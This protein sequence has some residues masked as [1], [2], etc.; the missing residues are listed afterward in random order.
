M[1]DECV[2]GINEPHGCVGDRQSHVHACGGVVVLRRCCCTAA[3]EST[4]CAHGDLSSTRAPTSIYLRLHVA[5][6]HRFA[7]QALCGLRGAWRLFIHHCRQWHRCPVGT[8]EHCT[9]LLCTLC[10][11]TTVQKI[12]PVASSCNLYFFEQR[13]F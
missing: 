9:P 4:Y 12:S 7:T 2:T 8:H 5:E 6:H 13:P 1:L 11:F 3:V 10:A